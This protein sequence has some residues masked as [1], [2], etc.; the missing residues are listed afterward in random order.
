[1]KFRAHSAE[2]FYGRCT[3]CRENNAADGPQ[4]NPNKL[5]NKLDLRRVRSQ[6]TNPEKKFKIVVLLK[7]QKGYDFGL[8]PSL[9]ILR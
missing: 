2:C 7:V 9:E 3:L 6:F 5:A 8:F 1:M 4:F